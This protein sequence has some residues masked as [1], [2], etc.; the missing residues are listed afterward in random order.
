M[1]TA[2][3]K[4]DLRPSFHQ[5][6]Y[7]VFNDA[8][9]YGDVAFFRHHYLHVNTSFASPLQSSF[10]MSAEGEVRVDNLNLFF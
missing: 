9:R 6:A 4:I 1:K 10:D 7:V 8:W 2:L 5:L 3:K